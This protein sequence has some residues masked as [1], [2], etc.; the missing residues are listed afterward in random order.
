MKDITE[1]ARRAHIRNVHLTT[2]EHKRQNAN[3]LVKIRAFTSVIHT[4]NEETNQ[5]VTKTYNNVKLVNAERSFGIDPVNLLPA[6]V[7]L[8]ERM[9]DM[10]ESA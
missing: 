2:R 4:K 5:F 8:E 3:A 10:T 1:S 9:K 7:L 6:R